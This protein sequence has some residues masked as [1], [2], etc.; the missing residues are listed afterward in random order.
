MAMRVRHGVPSA[1]MTS[2]KADIFNGAH[3]V[4]PDGRYNSSDTSPETHS[5]MGR[6]MLNWM[7]KRRLSPSPQRETH[8]ATEKPPARTM[9]GKYLLLY[10]Y[11]DARYANQVV[12]T[13]AQIEDLLGFTL[14]ARAR[15]NQEWWTKTETDVAGYAHSDCWILARRTATPNL[16]AQTVVF[17]RPS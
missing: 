2:E 16:L 1:R 15:L 10:N 9:S 5:D 14:P 11:L 13:F 6:P 4:R 7:K 12:L 3:A 17:E 8:G